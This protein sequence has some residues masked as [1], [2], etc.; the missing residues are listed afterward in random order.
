MTEPRTY[1]RELLEAA[2]GLV[3][4]SVGMIGM[5]VVFDLP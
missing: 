3:V 2:A 5:V 4:D 1:L